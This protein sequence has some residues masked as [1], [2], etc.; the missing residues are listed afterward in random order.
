MEF[1]WDDGN[2]GKCEKHGLKLGEI[3]YALSHGPRF[4]GDPAHSLT[5]E[6]FIAV[7]RTAEGRAVYIAFCW[8]DGKVRP[9][10]A[11]YMHRKEALRYGH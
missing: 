1:D 10:S 8:R 5:E 4:D 2:A 9:I 7:S 6:R 11:R 3:E